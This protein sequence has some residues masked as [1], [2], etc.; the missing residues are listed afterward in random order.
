VWAGFER[1]Y[2]GVSRG[3]IGP[4]PAFR[5]SPSPAGTLGLDGTRQ[6]GQ[7]AEFPSAERA[8]RDCWH[9]WEL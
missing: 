6:R 2:E 4:N 1:S 9:L 5:S 7:L 8:S 3:E